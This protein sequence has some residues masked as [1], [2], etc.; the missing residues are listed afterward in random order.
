MLDE[1]W[2]LSSTD[3]PCKGNP[4]QRL[5]ASMVQVSREGPR[6]RQRL[7]FW[8]PRGG[9]VAPLYPP[10]SAHVHVRLGAQSSEERDVV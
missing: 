10:L 5:G 3:L 6:A 4:L 8:H 7:P 1:P 9:D 2:Q